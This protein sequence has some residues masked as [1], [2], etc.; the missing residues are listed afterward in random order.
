ML[1]LTCA[2]TAVAAR[3]SLTTLEVKMSTITKVASRSQKKKKSFFHLLR[4]TTSPDRRPPQLQET[5]NEQSNLRT[6]VRATL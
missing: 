6:K 4:M 3:S 1:R 5:L 2:N